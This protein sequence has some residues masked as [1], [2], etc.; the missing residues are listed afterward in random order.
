MGVDRRFTLSKESK[1]HHVRART[2]EA[3]SNGLD[4]E[5][6]LL[7]LDYL[8]KYRIQVKNQP[9]KWISQIS[10]PSRDSVQLYCT[11]TT[12]NPYVN[13]LQSLPSTEQ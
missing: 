12:G 5:V 7:F 6:F 10:Q 4:L 2:A 3:M 11:R 13:P 9:P 1:S 8:K